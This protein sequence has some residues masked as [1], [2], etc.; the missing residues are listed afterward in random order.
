M[1]GRRLKQTVT[2]WQVRRVNRM[3]ALASPIYS[4]LWSKDWDT[5]SGRAEMGYTAP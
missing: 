2:R 1:I 5:A 4:D 3:A